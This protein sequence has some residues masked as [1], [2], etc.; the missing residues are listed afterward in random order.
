MVEKSRERL[1]KES[2]EEA[3]RQL[4][5]E[6]REDIKRA[7]KEFEETKIDARLWFEWLAEKE[8]IAE[9]ALELYL[10]KYAPIW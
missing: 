4:E 9:K 8:K 2:E 5:E 6:L 3:I 7:R 1:V 10:K